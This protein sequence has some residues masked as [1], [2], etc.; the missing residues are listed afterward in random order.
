M[1][2]TIY[3]YRSD[4]GDFGF[5]V[6]AEAKNTFYQDDGY[7]L[8]PTLFDKEQ[9]SKNYKKNRKVRVDFPIRYFCS[10][11]VILPRAG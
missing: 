3:V 4:E 1:R 5:S 8:L 6:K 11:D 9:R 10:N 7:K 2:I